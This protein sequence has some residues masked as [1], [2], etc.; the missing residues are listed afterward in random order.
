M[1]PRIP[2]AILALA[3]T[4][5]GIA[6][7]RV[8]I[9]D[10]LLDGTLGFLAEGESTAAGF[11]PLTQ[12]GHILYQPS[13]WPSKCT[14][15]FEAKGIKADTGNVDWD[16]AFLGVYD[17]RGIEE[18]A[19]YGN[20]FKE[21]YFRYNLHWRPDRGVIK[22]VINCADDTEQRRTSP[23]A[24]FDRS[25]EERD[26][27][28]EP[29]GSSMNWDENKWYQFSIT[30]T[31]DEVTVTIDGIQKWKANLPATNP[32]KPITPRI[33]LG[34]A[35]RNGKKYA[36]LYPNSLYRN[37]RMVDND[38]KHPFDD[39]T[40]EANLLGDDALPQADPNQN[41]L[42][43]L[44]EFAFG[45]SFGELNPGKKLAVATIDETTLQ[46]SFPQSV[47]ASLIQYTLLR[48]PNLSPATWEI[49]PHDPS[50]ANPTIEFPITP[51]SPP[52]FYRLQLKIAD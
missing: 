41:G 34:S 33:W 18:P 27:F 45:I 28:T 49:L 36:N 14:I 4:A 21:N 39:W 13:Y 38:F 11:A 1:K 16:S 35:P 20:Q 15:S 40:A 48:S 19:R 52:Q 3:S 17:G 43:N 51:D 5:A 46:I 23:L 9:D 44:E 2:I 10:P 24:V 22:C 26:W 31:E 12:S 42:S 47:D 30:W 8:L 25:I 7:E 29:N 32:Y 50:S 37:F 6:G